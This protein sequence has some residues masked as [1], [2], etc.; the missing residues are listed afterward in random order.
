MNKTT[1]LLVATLLSL[2]PVAVADEPL[3]H[4]SAAPRLSLR[5]YPTP[6]EHTT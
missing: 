6:K 5:E 2:A 1:T 3:T 4:G